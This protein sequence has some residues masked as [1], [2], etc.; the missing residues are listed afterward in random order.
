MPETVIEYFQLYGPFAVLFV[1]LFY[2]S[3][4]TSKERERIMREDSAKREDKLRE[5]IAIIRKE[6]E[7]RSKRH[8]EVLSQFAEKYDLIIDRLGGLETELRRR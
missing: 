7:E 5:E 6:S 3:L 8:Y 4:T 1:F 2:W